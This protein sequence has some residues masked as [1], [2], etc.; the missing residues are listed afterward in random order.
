M[1]S[2]VNGLAAYQAAAVP[3]VAGS[4]PAQPAAGA[5][6]GPDFGAMVSDAIGNVESAQQGADNALSMLA[7]GEHVDIHGTMIAMEKA[8]ITLRTLVS[9]RDKFISAYEQVMNMAV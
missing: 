3:G 4:A 9:V 5:S 2:G 1:I 8:D 7:S 6:N